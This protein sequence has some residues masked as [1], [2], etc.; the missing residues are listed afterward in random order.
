MARAG[1]G[2]ELRSR[3][4]TDLRGPTA[5]AFVDLDDPSRY[6]VRFR[7]RRAPAAPFARAVLARRRLPLFFP[8]LRPISA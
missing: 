7:P 5:T 4:Y 2:A 8:P 6:C 3:A 1:R